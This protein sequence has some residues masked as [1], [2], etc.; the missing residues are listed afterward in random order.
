MF[1]PTPTLDSV[2]PSYM[3]YNIKELNIH[4]YNITVAAL[5]DVYH[6]NRHAIAK[7]ETRD[8]AITGSDWSTALIQLRTLD[9]LWL[10]VFIISSYREENEYGL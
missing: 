10:E 7:A 9:L 8:V 2:M 4:D 5:N 3:F 6:R 1:L